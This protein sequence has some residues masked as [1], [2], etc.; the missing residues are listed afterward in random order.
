MEDSHPSM[1]EWEIDKKDFEDFKKK[2]GAAP[3][4][5]YEKP[6]DPYDRDHIIYSHSSTSEKYAKYLWD[7]YNEKREQYEYSCH[8]FGM[9]WGCI[10]GI[11]VGTIVGIRKG[12]GIVEKIKSAT[13]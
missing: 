10:V 8:K 5:R 12:E 11:I 13:V 4:E 7:R 2:I 3:S 9:L 1:E 6:Y